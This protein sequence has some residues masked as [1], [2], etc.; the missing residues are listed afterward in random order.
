MND[1][2]NTSKRKKFITM[3]A[4]GVGF[5]ANV[6]MLG[7]VKEYRYNTDYSDEDL[8]DSLHSDSLG[9]YERIL[10]LQTIKLYRSDAKVITRF[11]LG[12]LSLGMLAH[13][14][15]LALFLAIFYYKEQQ[16]FVVHLIHSLQIHTFS[17]FI[18][19]LAILLYYFFN[20]SI[21]TWV[22]FIASAAYL[23]F[24]LRQVY[25]K[26]IFSTFWRYT[27]IEILYYNYWV[28]TIA[29][30]IIISFLLF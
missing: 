20:T 25:P 26:S 6:N 2:K 16:P 3:N 7:A 10:A 28:I 19:A 29:V 14:P 22:T 9:K 5:N 12:N 13:V 21:F 23:F 8:L 11:I 17:L 15:S 27:S 1:N 18:Y 30:G 4:S 24:S